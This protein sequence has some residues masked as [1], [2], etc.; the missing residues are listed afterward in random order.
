VR[1]PELAPVAYTVAEVAAPTHEPAPSAPA[2]AAQAPITPAPVAEIH[3]ASTAPHSQQPL[4]VRIELAILEDG[5]RRLVSPAESAFRV[6]PDFGDEPPFEEPSLPRRPQFAPRAR[7]IDPEPAE[8]D[9]IEPTLESTPYPEFETAAPESPAMGYMPEL[10]GAPAPMSAPVVQ[11]MPAPQPQPA[12][13]LPLRGTGLAA[14][15]IPAETAGPVP[16]LQ[17]QPP[18]YPTQAP[19]NEPAPAY[20]QPSAYQQPMQAQ[21]EATFQAWPASPDFAPQPMQSQQPLRQQPMGSPQHSAYQEPAY[22]QPAYAMPAPAPEPA[23]PAPQF[24][25]AQTVQPLDDWDDPAWDAQRRRARPV[26]SAADTP[27]YLESGPADVPSPGLR[28]SAAQAQTDTQ[29]DLWFLQNDADVASSPVS[30]A[31]GDDP[32]VGREPSAVI[33]SVLTVGMAILV[34]V[35]VLVFI[36]LMTSLLR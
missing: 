15:L 14:G 12:A 31:V 2:P 34:I 9:W 33:T 4:V 29:S 27:W 7:A 32:E 5:S 10:D 6:G 25:P 28:G 36:Q 21:P 13:P 35:L 20:G 8:S 11:P 16:W 24:A 18:I 3:V 1:D 30:G 22:Q 23:P 19:T 17:P 26:A